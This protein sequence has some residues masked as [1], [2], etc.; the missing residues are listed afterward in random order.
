MSLLLVLDSPASGGGGSNWPLAP[1]FAVGGRTGAVFAFDDLSLVTT[2][3]VTPVSAPDDPIGQM[4]NQ[5][6]GRTYSVTASSTARP[7]YKVD[8]NGLGYARFDGVDD[9]LKKLASSV[10][11]TSNDVTIAFAYAPRSASGVKIP[12][13]NR[14]SSQCWP[15]LYSADA[16]AYAYWVGSIGYATS[17]LGFSFTANSKI[18]L[19]LT[20][21]GAVFTVRVN[22]AQVMSQ[23]VAGQDPLTESVDFTIGS[24]LVETGYFADIDFYAVGAISGA[25]SA[26]ELTTLETWAADRIGVTL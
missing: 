26:S 20:K 13:A 7:T 19:T 11:G 16:S 25:L 12:F 3:G 17:G 5:W 1:L 23:T 6:T 8:G 10:V 21:R 22:G 15:Q 18:V 4:D 14:G 9:Q 2:N 24:V